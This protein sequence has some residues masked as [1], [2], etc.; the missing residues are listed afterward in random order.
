MQSGEWQ[1]VGAK[2]GPGAEPGCAAVVFP[3]QPVGAWEG[4][5]G[6]L[7]SQAWVGGVLGFAFAA[8]GV[9]GKEQKDPYIY[10]FFK[11]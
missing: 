10:P 5:R 2:Q 1:L 11:G 8:T 9:W 6:D 4:R 7:S 3:W